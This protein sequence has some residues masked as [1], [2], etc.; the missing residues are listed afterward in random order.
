MGE[1]RDPYKIKEESIEPG[2]TDKIQTPKFTLPW[3]KCN[4]TTKY[5]LLDEF[6]ESTWADGGQNWLRADYALN[7]HPNFDKL[8]ENP[9]PTLQDLAL[10]KAESASMGIETYSEELHGNAK[11]ALN[12]KCIHNNVHNFWGG[13]QFLRPPKEGIH[14]WGAGHMSNVAMAAFDPIFFIYHNNIDRL[15]AMWQILN[16]EKWFDDDRSKL[17]KDNTLTPFHKD[18]DRNFW[19]SDDVRDWRALGYDY[20]ILQGRTHNYMDDRKGILKCIETLYGN[21]TKNL[22]EGLLKHHGDREDYVITVVY[23]KFAL[24]GAPYKVNLFLDGTRN[25]GGPDP[26]EISAAD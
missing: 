2:P 24:N 8:E 26:P 19:K 1:F 7:E 25:F 12:L 6:H 22:Y 23:D 21:P 10:T 14:L 13:F 20:E 9:V 5:G 16:W 4:A 18:A 17:I 11:N 3:D 15:T